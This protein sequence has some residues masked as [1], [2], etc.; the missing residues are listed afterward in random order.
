MFLVW[1]PACLAPWVASRG[2]CAAPFCV[3]V[4]M[5]KFVIKIVVYKTGRQWQ[6]A[7]KAAPFCF[8]PYDEEARERLRSGRF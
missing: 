6:K 5:V 1:H 4:V 8:N 7:A 3:G 2:L